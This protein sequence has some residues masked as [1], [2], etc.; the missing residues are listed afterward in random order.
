MPEVRH[1]LRGPEGVPAVPALGPKIRDGERVTVT[2]LT[3]RYSGETGT[4]EGFYYGMAGGVVYLVLI[5]GTEEALPYHEDEL[6]IGDQ[7]L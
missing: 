4:V 5:D 6:T 2:T 3:D 7:V 1:L